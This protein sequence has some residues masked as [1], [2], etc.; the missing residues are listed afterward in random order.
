M[1]EPPVNI[2]FAKTHL[3]RLLERVQAGE[4]ITI[5]KAGTPVAALVPLPEHAGA[6]STPPVLRE[7]VTPYRASP[8]EEPPPGPRTVTAREFAKRW[9]ALPRLSPDDAAA[10][11]RDVHEARRALPP[12]SAP[13]E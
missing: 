1:Q 7:T 8:P 9:S 12:P 4:R 6:A 13:W 5:A 2:H 3:S 10:M 11:E